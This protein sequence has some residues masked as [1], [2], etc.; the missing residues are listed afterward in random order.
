MPPRQMIHL[1]L[2]RFLIVI[3]WPTPCHSPNENKSLKWD[4]W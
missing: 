4:F 1:Y 2:S 3:R